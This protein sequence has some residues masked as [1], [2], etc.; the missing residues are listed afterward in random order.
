M[1]LRYVGSKP[2]N[3]VGERPA[4]ELMSARLRGRD[5]SGTALKTYLD[6]PR[7]RTNA[8]A[9]TQE[10]TGRQLVIAGAGRNNPSW[11]SKRLKWESL[12]D[13]IDVT[14]A[15]Q[16]AGL[17]IGGEA[18]ALARLN[19]LIAG[20]SPG[21]FAP[22]VEGLH[23]VHLRTRVRE[24]GP[25]LPVAEAI[26][27][28]E[29]YVARM[30]EVYDSDR[31]R[32]EALDDP[33]DVE[34]AL[35]LVDRL[36]RFLS[37]ESDW[38]RIEVIPLL[39]ALTMAHPQAVCS[40]IQMEPTGWKVLPALETSMHVAAAQSWERHRREQESY[41]VSRRHR[42]AFDDCISSPPKLVLSGEY[43]VAAVR[44]ALHVDRERSLL[45]G[46]AQPKARGRHRR[47][48]EHM[49]SP[50]A[51]IELDGE[52]HENAYRLIA[53]CDR[54][55]SLWVYGEFVD[56]EHW[57]IARQ[58][59]GDDP[60][61]GP[62]V[63]AVD[64]LRS[65]ATPKE[66]ARGRWRV[67]PDGELRD[68]APIRDFT[69]AL[70]EWAWY[71]NLPTDLAALLAPTGS[72]GSN[73]AHARALFHRGERQVP[74]FLAGIRTILLSPCAV[75]SRWWIDTV[76]TCSA[77]TRLSCANLVGLCLATDPPQHV[78]ERGVR[79][80]AAWEA[81]DLAGPILT[82]AISH[83]ETH[84][85]TEGVLMTVVCALL[86][87]GGK[88]EGVALR[89]ALHHMGY[90]ASQDECDW[91]LLAGVAMCLAALGED[92]EH[93]LSSQA[94]AR[95]ERTAPSALSWAKRRRHPL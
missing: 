59:Y 15:M 7:R 22:T 55:A 45:Q 10:L 56:T 34:A 68:P 85:Y 80:L 20:W 19:L 83:Y 11:L 25:E 2:V 5:L 87:L 37:D 51:P 77:R 28:A 33:E 9:G 4:V 23:W 69:L 27:A 78:L 53:D 90:L 44:R 71:E 6:V 40:Y 46:A 48:L 17:L 39:A 52:H 75:Q 31:G 42:D 67:T 29:A 50:D 94:C 43:W 66:V 86:D 24:S 13:Y 26:L 8:P 54:R 82:K 18:I 72:A 1:W 95:L 47:H 21:D 89:P 76:S 64:D 32:L 79:A 62:V 41:Q 38:R 16:K 74:A 73:L 36:C 92:P 49:L 65:Q 84:R 30:K 14:A 61:L 35:I 81:V 63:G 57:E 70:C 3:K 91:S 58:H 93:R 60:A 88:G 12:K